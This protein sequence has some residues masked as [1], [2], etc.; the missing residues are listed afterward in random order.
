MLPVRDSG[1]KRDLAADTLLPG[2]WSYDSP[3]PECIHQY[4]KVGNRRCIFRY[5]AA[6]CGVVHFI[7][8]GTC[9][10]AVSSCPNSLTTE[11]SVSRSIGSRLAWRIS[12]TSSSVVRLGCCSSEPAMEYIFVESSM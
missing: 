1:E 8:A 4:I 3:G 12:V 9:C 5:P 6:R 10:S 7:E 2:L 11:Y